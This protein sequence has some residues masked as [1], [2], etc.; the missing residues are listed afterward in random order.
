MA[1]RGSHRRRKGRK[2]KAFP[3]KRGEGRQPTATAHS[4][5][6][7]VGPNVC[8]GDYGA[9]RRPIRCESLDQRQTGYVGQTLGCEPH[10]RP[11]PAKEGKDREGGRA[12]Q[13]EVD[14]GR[15]SSPMGRPAPSRQS[16]AS[17]TLSHHR[18][19]SGKGSI[20]GVPHPA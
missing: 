7:D 3:G 13:A 5:Y 20:P 18:T 8:G 12:R 4:T 16:F 2:Q 9:P 14:S 1:A 11:Q 10:P 6:S 15:A 19:K 17:Y